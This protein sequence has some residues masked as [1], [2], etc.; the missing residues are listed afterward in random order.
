MGRWKKETRKLP[1]DHDWRC[2]PGHKIFVADRGAVR[3]DYPEDWIVIPGESS[4]QFHDKKPPDDH[5]I[6]EVSFLRL[7]PAI[8]WSELSL[9]DLLCQVLAQEGTPVPADQVVREARADLELVW[10]EHRSIDPTEHREAVHR[11]CIARTIRASGTTALPVQP[12]IQALLTLAFWP[13][14]AG[15]VTPVWD[16]VLRSLQLGLVIKDPTRRHLH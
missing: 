15:W 11:M 8:D 4:C 13:E 7:S 14:D 1:K 3:F 10:A 5:C 12:D 16:E 6:L 2:K 9:V